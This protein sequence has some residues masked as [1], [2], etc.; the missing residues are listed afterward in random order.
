VAADLPP[1]PDHYAGVAPGWDN[2]AARVYSPIAA[3]HV[4]AAPHP[5]HGRTVLDAG[6]GTG[7]AGRELAAALGARVVA[8]AQRGR[9]GSVRS[10][11]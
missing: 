7:L 3:R 1:R 9:A 4:A 6:A 5:L 11:W 2:H 8:A 10:G